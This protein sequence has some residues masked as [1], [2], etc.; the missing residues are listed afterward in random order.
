M[1]VG[2]CVRMGICLYVYKNVFCVKMGVCMF[3]N[4]FENIYD[5]LMQ[6]GTSILCKIEGKTCLNKKIS[7]KNY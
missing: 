5:E 3:K 4:L 1:G 7:F 2:V 6:G